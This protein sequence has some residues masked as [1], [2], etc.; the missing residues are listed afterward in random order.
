MIFF[1]IN[2]RLVEVFDKEKD[3]LISSTESH[4]TKVWLLSW[5]P[6]HMSN[7]IKI[8]RSAR[9]HSVRHALR[10]SLFRVDIKKKVSDNIN[11]FT[12]LLLYFIYYYILLIFL[13]SY[14]LKFYRYFCYFFFN[15]IKRNR[16][17][18]SFCKNHDFLG[19]SEKLFFHRCL[20]FLA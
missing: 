13:I 1:N 20:W 18:Q 15:E 9:F 19:R 12:L 6:L 14:S 11:T 4:V 17:F 2:R 7:S 5:K 16:K 10:K 3:V 8:S